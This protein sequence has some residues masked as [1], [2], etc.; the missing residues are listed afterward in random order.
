M[1]DDTGGN[2]RKYPLD[3]FVQAV[4]SSGGEAT[5]PEVTAEV[6]CSPETARRRMKELEDNGVVERR[7][8]GPTLV[9]LMATE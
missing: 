6:G 5:T 8:I 7:E 1:T 4:E 2:W 3:D 9:W